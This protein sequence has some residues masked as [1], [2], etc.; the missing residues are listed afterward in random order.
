MSGIGV[1]RGARPLSAFALAALL[2]LAASATAWAEDQASPPVRGQ[3]NPG[4]LNQLT[5]KKPPGYQGRDEGEIIDVDFVTG[6]FTPGLP[7]DVRFTLRGAATAGY[8]ELSA[9]FIEFNRVPDCVGF[10]Q[11]AQILVARD[12]VIPVRPRRGAQAIEQ[13]GF[14]RAT[15]TADKSRFFVELPPLRPNRYY[16]FE[17]LYKKQLEESELE[18]LRGKFAKAIDA[19]FRKEKYVTTSGGGQIPVTSRFRA[20]TLAENQEL[21]ETL[22][23]ILENELE[24]GQTLVA[25]PGSFFDVNTDFDDIATE[26][27]VAFR[28]IPE[29]SVV[30]RASSIRSYRFWIKEASETLQQLATGSFPTKDGGQATVQDILEKSAS[31]VITEETRTTVNL[32]EVF[33][34]VASGEALDALVDPG[35]DDYWKP[36]TEESHP[37]DEK[38]V[39]LRRLGLAIQSLKGMADKAGVLVDTSPVPSMAVDPDRLN[40]GTV[41]EGETADRSVTIANE[42]HADL[43]VTKLEILPAG[44][45][46]AVADA[47]SPE[48]PIVVKP[49]GKRTITV[50]FSPTADNT[51]KRGS[52]KITSNDQEN[53]E[54]RVGLNKDD[55]TA[56]P[57]GQAPPPTFSSLVDKA[58]AALGVNT[59]ESSGATQDLFDLREVVDQ[60]WAAIEAI[61]ETL[62][63]ELRRSVLIS[64]T[65]VADYDTRAM[66]YMSADIGSGFSP[67]TEDFFTYVGWN[68]YFRP[69]NKKAHLSWSG[70]P[71]TLAEEFSRRFSIT[72]GL[73]QSGVDEENGRFQG[74]IA[75]QA[76]VLGAGFRIND[77][78]RLSAGALVFENESPDPLVSGSELTWAPYAALSFDWNVTQTFANIFPGGG[79]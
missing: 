14:R 41:Q 22:I 53:L 68:I 3:A 73:V 7:F 8:D 48:D 18:E 61:T 70:R 39:A 47:P 71:F 34:K 13:S 12:D 79:L 4:A 58:Q 6:A 25:E 62:G 29:K 50:T 1:S 24:P 77:A 52:L 40:F 54:F 11:P 51:V 33:A 60:R 23:G 32:G 67:D 65:T 63:A 64:G 31:D 15:F 16:C 17:F 44:A 66:W 43:E 69:I 20:A 36:E 55:F 27:R 2:A 26:Y 35:V 74:V 56:G 5:Q 10:F 42:G 76:A 49:G 37:F 75:D 28:R 45:P 38:T 57:A 78:L 21:R 30:Q 72:L 9:R 19:E 46:F 59:E